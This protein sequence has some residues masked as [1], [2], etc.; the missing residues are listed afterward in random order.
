M[1][2]STD[3]A[4][5]WDAAFFLPLPGN[6]LPGYFRASLTGLGMATTINFSVNRR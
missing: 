3:Q 1:A 5:R 6:E 4:S 2:S